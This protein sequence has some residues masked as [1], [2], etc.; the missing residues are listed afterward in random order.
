VPIEITDTFYKNGTAT[1]PTTIVYN[2]LGPDGTV[3][4][5]TFPGAPEISNPAAGEFVLSLSPPS[6]PGLYQY[7][8]NATGTVV[9]SRA[10]SFN[11]L[12]DASVPTEINWAVSGPCSP[13]TSSTG[14]WT[15]CGQPTTTIDGVV[16]AVDMS[17]EAMMASQV[18]YELSGRR[19]SGPC[20]ITVRPC[21]S[22]CFCGLQVLSRGYVVG[23]WDW[24]GGSSWY[25]NGWGWNCGDNNPCGCAPLSR[26]LLSGYPVREVLEVKIDGD[27]VDPDTYRLDERRWLVRTRTTA[28]EQ[29][30]MWPSC[31]ALDLPDTEDGTFSVTYKYGMDPPIIAQHA[32]Q[33]LACQFFRLCSSDADCVLPANVSRTTRLGV[34]TER[35]SVLSWFYS[36]RMERGWATGMATVD[37]FLSAYASEAQRRRPVTWSPDGARYA[38]PSGVTFGP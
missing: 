1:N 23:P 9:A 32:A 16:C 4:T 15:C 8:V 29:A 25:W 36:R 22:D 2:L 20:E 17:A 33:E 26:V 35:G 5:Y 14:V 21:R 18:L 34:T 27:I 12:A 38:R 11:V 30:L 24:N 6:L 3:T 31:Q 13:W 10:G 28:D 19:F 7:D 37:A